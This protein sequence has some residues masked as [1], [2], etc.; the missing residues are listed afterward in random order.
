MTYAFRGAIALRMDALIKHSTWSPP[1]LVRP[2][3]RPDSESSLSPSSWPGIRA[4]SSLV[5]VYNE[6]LL[7]FLFDE[8]HLKEIL[9]SGADLE[10]GYA[11]KDADVDKG[12]K[13]LAKDG[14]LLA[15]ELV[16]DD[17]VVIEVIV[18]PPLTKKELAVG[19]WL[20]PQTGF[21]R[22]PGGVL[23]ID[24][25]NTL[26]IGGDEPDEDEEPGRVTIPPGNYSLTLY[27]LDSDKVEA[28]KLLSEDN[29]WKGPQEVLLLT[30]SP[31]GQPA[32]S[33]KP[34]LRIPSLSTTASWLRKY[35]IADGVFAGKA[36]AWSDQDSCSVNIDLSAAE[37]LGIS[38]GVCLRIEVGDLAIEAVYIGEKSSTFQQRKWAKAVSGDR[39]EFGLIF[40]PVEDEV[41]RH[42]LFVERIIATDDFPKL[43]K[44]IGATVTVLTER[45]EVPIAPPA[46]DTAEGEISADE[47]A[48]IEE[49]FDE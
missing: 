18:G 13:K 12:L 22:L 43:K 25:A 34:L 4:G 29:E 20:K 39:S 1:D 17:A 23:R 31:D 14:S 11:D 3:S 5:E 36:F 48:E 30:L 46:V 27:R 26:P 24:T 9:E 6:A 42:S 40:R 45:F 44:W 10:T 38:V 7:V 15:Y 28:D 19:R 2:A 16:Q 49:M 8:S 32:K 35:S 21:L 41:S 33:A 47:L 37:Q